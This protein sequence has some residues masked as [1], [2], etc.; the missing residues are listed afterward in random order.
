[1]ALTIA[2]AIASIS[3]TYYREYQEDGTRAAI[4]QDLDALR[5][6]IELYE[7][8]TRRAYR[9]NTP[10]V[11][12]GIG[13]RGKLEDLWG[14]PYKIL[15]EKCIVYSFGPN[16]LDDEGTVD[17]IVLQ[18]SSLASKGP[19]RAPRQLVAQRV[20]PPV[21]LSWQPPSGNPTLQGYRVERRLSDSSVWETISTTCVAAVPAPTFMD[22]AP[23]G[24]L[25]YYRVVAIAEDDSE[26]PPSD[27]TG[28]ALSQSS[29]PQLYIS[30][31]VKTVTNGQ[32]VDFNIK[33]KSFGA[34]LQRLV[35]DG[36]ELELNGTEAS[37]T[38][39]VT[40]T[41][42]RDF[43]VEVFDEESQRTTVTVSITVS[44]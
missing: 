20:G 17:D 22:S 29:R 40:F 19:L 39:Q 16:G 26:S 5:R 28:W 13:Y 7:T 33:L 36:E 35:F 6:T 24:N 25:V 12:V 37:L 30:P 34:P 15:P 44:T 38:R 27:Q 32:T 43:E 10:P 42:S 23:G 11:G 8:Q 4:K 18:Y 3:I 31:R 21:L 2:A 41:R 1:M 14:N 9:K